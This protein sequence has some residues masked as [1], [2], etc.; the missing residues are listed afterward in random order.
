MRLLVL[1]LYYKTNKKNVFMV[2]LSAK[3][4]SNNNEHTFDAL[5]LD[6]NLKFLA[7]EMRVKTGW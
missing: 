2:I 3:N 7:M 1:Y 6:K 4:S 5:E